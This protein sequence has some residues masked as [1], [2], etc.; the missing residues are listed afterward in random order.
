[1]CAEMKSALVLGYTGATGREVV[2]VLG[3]TS[4]FQKVVL[5]GRR[6][7]DNDDPKLQKFVSSNLQIITTEKNI[8]YSVSSEK[9]YLGG[10]LTCLC[11]GLT[12]YLSNW[13]CSS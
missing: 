1:M 12:P 5:I 6:K 4:R 9:R 2:K 8:G 7:V 3:E 11:E 10:G 13:W